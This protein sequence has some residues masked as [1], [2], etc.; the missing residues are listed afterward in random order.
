MRRPVTAGRDRERPAARSHSSGAPMADRERLGEDRRGPLDRGRR[1]R[2]AVRPSSSAIDVEIEARL[3]AGVDQ[4][5]VAQV[6]VDVQRDAVVADAALD[7]QAERAD[8]AGGRPRPPSIQQ[9]GWPSRRIASTP[10]RGAGLDHRRLERRD[11]RPDEQAAV[12]E[13]QDRVGDELARAVVGHLAAALD[14][15]DLDAARR[16]APAAR[17]GRGASSAWRPRVRTASCSR[18]SSRS[19]ISPSARSATSSFWSC[20]ASR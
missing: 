2:L 7:A 15:D 14:A 13:P 9:P 6:D 12:A 19:P 4:V 18:S 1:R 8:L 16:R 3:A 17:P 5:E 20:Q 10:R 11:E